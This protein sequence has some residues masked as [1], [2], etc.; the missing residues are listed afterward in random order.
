MNQ[1]LFFTY[2]P[3]A[4]TDLLQQGDV[5]RRSEGLKQILEEIHK[6]Y[7]IKDDYTHFLVLTQT[8][9]LVRRR[10]EPCK[11]RYITLAAVRP[12]TL[13]V[14]REVQK[15]QDHVIAQRANVCSN[16]YRQKLHDFVERLLNNN[17]PEY[18]YLHPEPTL[19]FPY[20]SCA[21]L[22]LSISIK[23]EHYDRCVEARLLSLT[24]VFQAK[25]GWL[26][27]NVYSRVGTDEWV[28]KYVNQGEFTKSIRQ[29]LEAGYRWV[30][31]SK[32]K[33]AIE[34]MREDPQT[35]SMQELRD[36][37]GTVQVK[38]HREMIVEAITEE[39]Q[40]IG[41]IASADDKTKFLTRLG[42]NEIFK[43]ASKK[44]G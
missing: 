15:Y 39:L 32:L 13:V 29:I 38:T 41:T 27:G 42:N 37:I 26:V 18:F 1:Q 12:L 23:I 10:G 20:A 36:F 6:Y 22:R 30:D 3:P 21:F 35:K 8:C 25:L 16:R 40:K 43:T 24:D 34:Q 33:A 9:D 11:A 14:E 5:L 2:A 31:D 28:P 17:E 4:S 19:Q 44:P 7:S